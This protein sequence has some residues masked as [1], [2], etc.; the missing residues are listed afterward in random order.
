M[1][2]TTVQY[3]FLQTVTLTKKLAS[4]S[5]ALLD[6]LCCSH[7]INITSV[8]NIY[9]SPQ[10]VKIILINTSVHL[11]EGVSRLLLFNDQMACYIAYEGN[12]YPLPQTSPSVYVIEKQ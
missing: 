7:N 2:Y 4:D 12:S 10:H 9:I 8:I 1:F 5:V 3:M 6:Y 11:T